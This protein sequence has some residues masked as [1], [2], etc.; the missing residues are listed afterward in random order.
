[1][2]LMTKLRL[3][4]L[5]LVTVLGF[6]PGSVAHAQ[7]GLDLGLGDSS[8]LLGDILPGDESGGLVDDVVDGVTDT[9]DGIVDPLQNTIEGLLGD[10]QTG[11]L[12][13]GVALEAVAQGFALP[14]DQLLAIIAEYLVGPVIDVQLL[15]VLETL[16][17]E[18]KTIGD[19][20]V[21]Y[22]QLF[23]AANGAPVRDEGLINAHFGG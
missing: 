7:L 22:L 5:M 21:V 9:V 11:V 13:H 2:F 17:Y 16:V 20:G 1:M 18:V 19:G 14:L 15:W 4:I 23:Y 8:G 12:E 3:P 6:A 10:P